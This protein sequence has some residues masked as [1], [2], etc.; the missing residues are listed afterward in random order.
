MTGM[1]RH[2]VC[3][4]LYI[5]TSSVDEDL[6]PDLNSWYCS[7]PLYPSNSHFPRQ[8]NNY[9][10]K[11]P[12]SMSLLCICPSHHTRLIGSCPEKVINCNHTSPNKAFFISKGK[13]YLSLNSWYFARPLCLS[14]RYSFK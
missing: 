2:V 8:D 9:E 13:L 11:N 12:N 5:Y 14:H 3:Y 1:K 7:R 10:Q 4:Y 6:R